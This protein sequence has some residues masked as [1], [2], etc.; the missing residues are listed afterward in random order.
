MFYTFWQLKPLTF[1]NLCIPHSNIYWFTAKNRN[2]TV[3]QDLDIF[4][5]QKYIVALV[6]QLSALCQL[7]KILTTMSNTNLFN[8]I[9]FGLSF[10][11]IFPEKF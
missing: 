1:I 3:L 5:P 11:A 2:K 4:R 6:T 9:M 8:V 7:N 10:K